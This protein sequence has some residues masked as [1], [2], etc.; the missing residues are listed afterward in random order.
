MSTEVIA[1][2]VGLMAVAVTAIFNFL[3]ADREKRERV[4]GEDKASGA[5]QRLSGIME[6]FQAR[7]DEL[8]IDLKTSVDSHSKCRDQLV[9]FEAR[10][11]SLE[12]L[13][14]AKGDI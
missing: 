5:T 8:E 3:K 2:T 12:G 7:I 4:A 14:A 13:S 9:T 1:T 11:K 6:T 10:I